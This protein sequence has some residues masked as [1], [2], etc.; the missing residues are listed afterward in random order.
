MN[1]R[2]IYLDNIRWITLCFVI[3]YHVFYIFNSSGVVSNIGVTGIKE[4]DSICVFIYPWIMC[5]LFVVSG[6]A[7][8]YSLK[9]KTNKEFIKD[10]AKRILVPSLIGIFVYGW[11]SGW[12][13]NY[14][15]DIFAGNG[16]MIPSPIKYIIFSLI[17][18]GPLWYAHVLFVASLLIV[19]IRK[20]DKKQKL[21]SLFNKINLPILFLLFILVWGSSYILNTPVVTV[22][23]WGIYLLMF[24][25]GYYIFSNDVIIEKLEKIS[26]PLGI[27]TFIMGIIFTI[28]NYGANFGEN[29]FLTNIFTNIYIWL[30]ILSAFGLAKKFLNFDNKFTKYMNKNN[31]SF[32]VLHY[33]LQIIIA[34]VLVE[35]IKFNN[36]IFNYIFLIIGTIIILPIITEIIKRIPI[37]NKILLGVS[38]KK[39]F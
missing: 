12:T 33:T 14:Y 19:L 21:D 23:R 31:F 5:L 34:F 37:I 30:V 27:I 24:I 8:K 26:I 25:L 28:I 38:K 6:V 29:E 17:G 1:E 4:L 10:R 36:F 16:N 3:L 35:Y 11:I 20:N 32:Y 39:V 22:Y 9:N 13:T 15:N 2:K 7:A 18:I